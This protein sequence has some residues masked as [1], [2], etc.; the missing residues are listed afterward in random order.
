MN[1][2]AKILSFENIEIVNKRVDNIYY[3]RKLMLLVNDIIK[4]QSKIT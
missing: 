1:K 2:T 4:D 3:Q